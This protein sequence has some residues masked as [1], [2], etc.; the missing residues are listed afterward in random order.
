M[1]ARKTPK[2][3]MKLSKDPAECKIFH[4]TITQPPTRVRTIAPRRIFMY[5]GNKLV[6]SFAPETTVAEM[7]THSC[8]KHQETPAKKAAALPAGP[9]QV[10][11]MAIGSQIYSPKTTPEAEVTTIPMIAIQLHI[12]GN[13]APV[14]R[15]VFPDLVY[16]VKSAMLTPTVDQLAVQL[17]NAHMISQLFSLPVTVACWRQI[18]PL[19]PARTQIQITI[20]MTVAVVMTTLAAKSQRNLCGGISSM[21]NWIVQM[22]KYDTICCVVIPTLSGI[23]FAIL[24]Y[25]GQIARM[26]WVVG[27]T[28]R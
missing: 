6:K 13:Q 10:S 9:S 25:D 16:R 11:M 19:P 2:E 12:S 17:F 20:P 23:W 21:G 26:T 15:D 28:A 14:V 24:R 4:G 18:S 3:F 22:T 1:G 8:A 5:L 7:L 27:A